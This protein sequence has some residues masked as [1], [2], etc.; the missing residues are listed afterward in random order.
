MVVAGGKGERNGQLLSN[1][2][3][4]SLGKMKNSGDGR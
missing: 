3:S 1:G 2:Y 4:F